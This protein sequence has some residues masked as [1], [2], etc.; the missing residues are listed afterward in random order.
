MLLNQIS[1]GLVS[2]IL[3]AAFHRSSASPVPD[4]AETAP[5][6]GESTQSQAPP[7][8]VFY[9]D[10]PHMPEIKDLIL[11]QGENEC[12]LLLSVKFKG[13]QVRTMFDVSR[14]FTHELGCLLFDKRFATSC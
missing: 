8:D 2:L 13:E 9:Y 5:A 3:A 14:H 6:D 4:P 7:P 1:V 10:P 11:P 12:N